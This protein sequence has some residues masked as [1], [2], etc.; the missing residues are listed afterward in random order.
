MSNL[1]DVRL[2]FSNWM[3]MERTHFGACW[4]NV[5]VMSPIYV[6]RCLICCRFWRLWLVHGDDSAWELEL[7]VSLFHIAWSLASS[8]MLS[9]LTLV[10][11][12]IHCSSVPSFFLPTPC[13]FN[14]FAFLSIP[15]AYGCSRL[16]NCSDE[17]RFI[18]SGKVGIIYF[19]LINV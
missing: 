16:R 19:Q 14:T 17:L 15:V 12:S 10:L 18:G 11:D 9:N 1:Q 6:R 2:A 7:F 8:H 4:I 5:G 3:H 13:Y